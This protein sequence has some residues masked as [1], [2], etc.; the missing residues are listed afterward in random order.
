MPI[1]FVRLAI[2]WLLLLASFWVMQPYLLAL[3][4]AST[5]RT[6]AP[7]GNLAA[8]EQ[9]TIELF[10]NASPSVVHVFARARPTISMFSQEQERNFLP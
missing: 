2:I 8:S 9:S 4:S 7:R 3:F 6:V 5:P 10:K 1:R